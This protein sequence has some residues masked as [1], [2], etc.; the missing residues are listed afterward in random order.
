MRDIDYN[1]II[2]R[3]KFFRD[4]HKNHHHIYFKLFYTI[5]EGFAILFL[6]L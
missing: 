6:L 3:L 5:F 1:E 4:I 2:E